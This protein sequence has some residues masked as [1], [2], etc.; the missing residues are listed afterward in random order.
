MEAT[1]AAVRQ[2]IEPVGRNVYGEGQVRRRVY[3]LQAAIRQGNSGGPFVLPDGR[4]AGIAEK[5]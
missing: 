4:V 2:V 1:A 5:N 3:E